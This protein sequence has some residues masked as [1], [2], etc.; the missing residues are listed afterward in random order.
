MTIAALVLLLASDLSSAREL[1]IAGNRAEALAMLEAQ[2]AA[3]P[4]DLDA[5]TLYGIVLSWD[6]QFDRARQELKRVLAADPNNGDARAALTNVERWDRHAANEVSAGL[7]YDDY[8]DADDWREI[9]AMYK[10][11]MFVG[12][13]GRGKRFG[14]ED[15]AVDV[16]LYPRF[17]AKD[18]AYLAAGFSENG[19]LYPDWRVAAEYFLGFGD[20]FEASAGLRHLHFDDPVDIYAASIGKY[21]GNW[22]VSARGVFTEDSTNGQLLVRRYTDSRSYFGIRLGTGREEIRSAADVETLEQTEAVAEARMQ[23]TKWHVEVWAGGSDE[24]VSGMAAVG[25]RF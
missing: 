13:V 21:A 7:Q 15:T 5:R 14:L 23:F 1:A 9:Y 11:G 6:R 25:F 4:E 2:L 24:R 16:E 10:R 3:N 8:E 17:R 12:R 20:G 19:E 22:Y 18:Y